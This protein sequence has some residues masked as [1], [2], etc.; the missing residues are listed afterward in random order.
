MIE[1]ASYPP[2]P[3][4]T[5]SAFSFGGGNRG[6]GV[7]VEGVRMLKIEPRMKSLNYALEELSGVGSSR[8]KRQKEVKSILC[9]LIFFNQKC[10]FAI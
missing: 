10:K 1:G 6:L 9:R 8:R 5:W 4:T 3:V 2:P 7:G